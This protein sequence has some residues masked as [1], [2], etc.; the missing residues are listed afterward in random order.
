M[1]GAGLP[2]RAPDDP[3][4][5]APGGGLISESNRRREVGWT[6]AV[7]HRPHDLRHTAASLFI[8][9]GADLKSV[10][11]LL[12]HQSSRTTHDTYGHLLAADHLTSAV[13][14]LDTMIGDELGT[15]AEQ[16]EADGDD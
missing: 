14:R 2:E 8:A 13:R 11:S 15:S 9:A 12:G 4:F 6:T 10:Q 1:D 5:A 16:T 7:G 3:L